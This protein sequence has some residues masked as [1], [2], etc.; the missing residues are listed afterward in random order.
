MEPLLQKLADRSALIA[1]IGQGYVG[2]PVAMRASQ[3][4]YRTVGFD[5]SER[6]VESL[7]SGISFVGDIS[8]TELAEALARGYLP[9]NDPDDL[10]GF[11]VA[12]ISVPTPLRDG[13]PDLAFIESAGRTVGAHLR[14]GACVI[15]ESTTYPGT[16]TE[17]LAPILEEASG[18]DVA[19]TASATPPSASTRATRR[20]RS[21][22]LPR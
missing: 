17:L 8:D 12:V 3:V 11:D 20:T 2:L 7:R 10:A 15:L 19:R 4:G 22:T 6:R 16:T 14:E 13:S 21:S 9:S 1:V 18:L 5:V